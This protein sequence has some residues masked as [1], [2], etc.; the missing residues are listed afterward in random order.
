MIRLAKPKTHFKAR[1]LAMSIMAVAASMASHANADAQADAQALFEEG[2]K[3]MQQGKHQQACPKLQASLKLD[4]ALGTRFHL[5]ECY[6]TVGK[7]ASAWALFREAAAKSRAEQLYPQATKAT[8]RADALEPKLA[9]VV[10]DV[11]F[12]VATVRAISITLDGELL[13]DTSW[14]VP[15]PVDPGKHLIRVTGQGKRPYSTEFD[16]SEATSKTIQIPPLE[17][18]NA[19]KKNTVIGISMI[20]LGAGAIIAGSVFGVMSLDRNDAWQKEFDANCE[21]VTGNC[22]LDSIS[23]IRAIESERDKYATL[24]T[25]GFIAGATVAAAGAVVWIAPWQKKKGDVSFIPV[26]PGGLGA[27]LHGSF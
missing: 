15:L 4:S 25:I 17:D 23:T 27:T 9:K 12:E 20:G 8:A 7:T 18:V 1:V 26:G 19:I 14:D 5:A 11:P 16:I 10:L 6:E 22:A 24:S 2:M 3:L 13:G 21:K